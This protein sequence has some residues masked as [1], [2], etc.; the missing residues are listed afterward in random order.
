[1]LQEFEIEV[2]ERLTAN[3]LTPGQTNEILKNHEFAGLEFTGAGYF[4]S[5]K[6]SSIPEARFVCSRPI[7]TGQTED[8]IICGFVIF[9]ENNRLTLEC[10]EWGAKN[11]PAD[12]REKSI[13]IS[14]SEI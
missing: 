5:V 14:V 3:T 8:G 13:K 7:L 4:L 2:I 1:M 6:S 11:I 12:F 10:H 9:I